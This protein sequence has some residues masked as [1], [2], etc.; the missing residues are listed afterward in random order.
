VSA[1]GLSPGDVHRLTNRL[2]RIERRRRELLAQDA[3][4]LRDS[5]Q[6]D[7]DVIR[8]LHVTAGHRKVLINRQAEIAAP[9]GGV[10]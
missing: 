5:S 2:R 1:K 4:V 7:V 8:A 3:R 9:L 10:A 6:G